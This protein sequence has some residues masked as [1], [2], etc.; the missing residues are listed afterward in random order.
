MF[1]LC[2]FDKPQ[3][4][5]SQNICKCN[6][7]MSIVLMIWTL[8]FQINVGT[9]TNLRLDALLILLISHPVQNWTFSSLIRFKT[10]FL[11]FDRKGNSPLLFL[12]I[13]SILQ[14]KNRW[15]QYW[16]RKCC[17]GNAAL[18]Y[19]IFRISALWNT[20]QEVFNGLSYNMLFYFLLYIFSSW[21][22]NH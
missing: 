2:K 5:S 16:T 18:R 8:R 17:L 20:L 15:L 12:K 21:I 6:I 11:V 3:E 14:R 9:R 4:T 1:H 19:K 22:K 13:K 10:L 7:P